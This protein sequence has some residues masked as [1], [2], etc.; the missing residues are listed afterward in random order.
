[1]EPSGTVL[2]WLCI[3][4]TNMLDNIVVGFVL[5]IPANAQAKFWDFWG[6]GVMCMCVCVYTYPY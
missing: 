5:K 3:N 1:M 4:K 2:E 6:W